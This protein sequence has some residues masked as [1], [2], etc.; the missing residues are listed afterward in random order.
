MLHIIKTGDYMKRRI[1][2]LIYITVV[3]LVFLTASIIFIEFRI[4]LVRNEIS[5]FTAKNTASGAILNGVEEALKETNIY[6]GDIV[7]IEND[8]NGNVK[9]IQ[10]D[11]AKL[12]IISNSVN[13][14]V[15]GRVSKIKSVPV[16]IPISSVLGDEIIAGLGPS[17]TFYVTMTGS[18]STKFK[19]VFDSTGI[20]Q[21]RHQII[22]DV[23][24]D[25][26]VVFGS[27]ID[28]FTSQSNICVAES[29]IVGESPDALAQL[30]K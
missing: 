28:K 8:E 24:V 3:L 4:R 21:T 16:K 12:N 2:Y 9:S 26:Y 15:D 20:N 10:T 14:N 5:E 7:S 30:T 13:R 19:N 25:I 17:V 22:L 23:S 27:K 11:T 29:I 1:R 18:A 6:Y